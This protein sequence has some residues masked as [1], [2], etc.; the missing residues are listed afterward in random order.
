MP[1]IAL[2]PKRDHLLNE[3]WDDFLLARKARRCTPATLA[4]YQDTAGSFVAWA[5]ERG[6]TDPTEITA[7]HVREYL[8]GVEARG[9][10]DG[11]L[12]AHARA[13]RTY[14]RFLAAEG[15]R[16]DALPVEIPKIRQQSRPCLT[17]DELRRVVAACK[18][19]R[20]KAV[21]LT[22]ADTGLRR[23]EALALTW[24]DV[25]LSAATVRV[26]SGKGRKARTVIVGAV[27][28]RALMAYRRAVRHDDP[29]P[30]F[31]SERGGPLRSPGLRMLL[32]RLAVRSGVPH[33]GAHAL[34]RTFATLSLRAGM[35]VLTLRELL[36]HSDLAQTMTYVRLVDDDL[37]AAHEAH[38]PVDRLLSR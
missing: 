20:E 17:G 4:Y 13:T 18:T 32:R 23:S 31:Q 19:P 15:Y 28:R 21:I 6:I 22:L 25:D 10:S 2:T 33:L 38:G 30:V 34:R 3:S 36:G 24:G 37:R 26:V 12:H 14:L 27:T 11:T 7:R 1:L 29:A 9:V 35:D 16:P 5:A 8:A